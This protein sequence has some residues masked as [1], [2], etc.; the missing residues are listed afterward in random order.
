MHI[1]PHHICHLGGR[2]HHRGANY[3]TTLIAFPTS[4]VNNTAE[5]PNT[6]PAPSYSPTS[7]A[8]NTANTAIRHSLSGCW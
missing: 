2:K 3:T 4:A 5:I 6:T 1:S 8:E 7:A